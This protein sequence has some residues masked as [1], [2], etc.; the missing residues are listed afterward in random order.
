MAPA[1]SQKFLLRKAASHG[2]ICIETETPF[3]FRLTATSERDICVEKVSSADD[4]LNRA[5]AGSVPP[6]VPVTLRM[7][8]GG[9]EPCLL[10]KHTSHYRSSFHVGV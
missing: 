5:P 10:T 6:G 2:D 1:P 3:V 9:S 4:L 8:F 7:S